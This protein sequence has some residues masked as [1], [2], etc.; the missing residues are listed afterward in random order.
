MLERGLPTGILDR[1]VF[2]EDHLLR[3]IRVF[4]HNIPSEQD[5]KNAERL[6]LALLKVQ[7]KRS[8][9]HRRRNRAES[10]VLEIKVLQDVVH[11]TPEQDPF[12]EGLL[13]IIEDSG[14]KRIVIE[15]AQ[16]LL[17]LRE[18]EI[19][20]VQQRIASNPRPTLL[21]GILDDLVVANPEI[22]ATEAVKE[23]RKMTG[24]GIVTSVSNG[25]IELDDIKTGRNSTVA[26]EKIRSRLGHAKERYKKRSR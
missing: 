16:K 24:Q 19:T 20:A 15:T 4:L 10:I 22:S 26:I 25:S 12:I 13:K 14:T 6:L 3:S 17:E 21:G 11:W 2:S 9:L 23:I 8:N 18:N 5:E 1:R 7:R